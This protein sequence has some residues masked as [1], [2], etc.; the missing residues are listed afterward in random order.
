MQL[1]SRFKS[2]GFGL[3][4]MGKM[5]DMFNEKFDALIAKLDEILAELR[6]QRGS[7]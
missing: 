2:M 3:P 6:T 7:P 4:D 5:T 1:R